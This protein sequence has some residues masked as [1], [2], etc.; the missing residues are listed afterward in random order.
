MEAARWCRKAADQGHA[1]AQNNLG[2]MFYE[3]RGVA[4]SGVEAA[5]W[6]RKAADGIRV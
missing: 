4:Q 2:T 3:G 5:R 1:L 6:Y